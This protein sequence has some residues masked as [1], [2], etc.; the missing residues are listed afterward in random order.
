L[1]LIQPLS[2]LALAESLQ[3]NKQ[4][5]PKQPLRANNNQEDKVSDTNSEAPIATEAVEA[6]KSEPV[7]LSAA[8]PVAYTK[9]RSPNQFTSSLFRAFN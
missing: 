1:S 6:A 3:V 9:P 4:R 5:I 2:Q 7:A 8:Q